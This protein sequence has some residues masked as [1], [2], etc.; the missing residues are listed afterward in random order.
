MQI[1]GKEFGV[2]FN[3]YAMEQLSQVKGFTDNTFGFSAAMV[4]G[5]YCGWAFAKQLER[6]LTFENISDWVEE[7]ATAEQID[8]IA[9]VFMESKN[10]EKLIKNLPEQKK[11]EPVQQS[12]GIESINMPG[13]VLDSNQMNITS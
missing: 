1:K 11:S 5:G 8:D 10:Y 7:E 4:W 2:K 6:E 9:K 3:N 12:N 13:A